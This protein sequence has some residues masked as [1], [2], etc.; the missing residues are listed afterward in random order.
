VSHGTSHDAAPGVSRRAS[1]SIP[2]PGLRWSSP[3]TTT[4]R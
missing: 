2:S 3:P 1:S 4:T